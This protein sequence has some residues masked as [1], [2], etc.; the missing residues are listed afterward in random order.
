MQI[1]FIEKDHLGDWNPEKDCC[2]RLTFRQPVRKR[3]SESSVV[4]VENSKTLVSDRLRLSLDSE[5][6]FRTGCR[7]VSR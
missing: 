2:Q 3:S 6:G 7:N 1:T 5:D 4:L